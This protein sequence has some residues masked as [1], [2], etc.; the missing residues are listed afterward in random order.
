MTIKNWM[1]AARLALKYNDD[2]NLCI[3]ADTFPGEFPVP[4]VCTKHWTPRAWCT[5]FL[6]YGQDRNVT[7]ETK[8]NQC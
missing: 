7:T 6:H 5:W 4:S 8:G 1:L 2:I 3:L